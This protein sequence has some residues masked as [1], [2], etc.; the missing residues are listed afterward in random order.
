MTRPLQEAGMPWDEPRE[1][2]PYQPKAHLAGA[3]GRL[4]IRF[5]EKER[6]RATAAYQATAERWS[7]K[8]EIRESFTE[9]ARRTLTSKAAVAG[10]GSQ[11]GDRQNGS[12][13]LEPV[14]ANAAAAADVTAAKPR[15]SARRR[16]GSP[17]R[18]AKRARKGGRR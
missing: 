5:S 8:G 15:G 11:N 2:R 13:R 18:A 14:A 12:Q 7:Y 10:D 3:P 4:T 16:R 9:W 17:A 1:L 6:E